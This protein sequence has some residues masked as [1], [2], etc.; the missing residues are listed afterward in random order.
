MI[1]K[2]SGLT[3]KNMRK[4]TLALL[5]FMLSACVHEELQVLV[6][7]SRQRSI[8]YQ[9]LAPADTD[10]H[11]PLILISHGSGGEINNHRWL[12]DALVNE[13][14]IAAAVNHPGNTTMDDSS[15]GVV[16]VWDRP[17]DLTLLLDAL[18]ADPIWKNRIDQT[19]IGAAGFSSGGYTALALAGARYNG[20]LLSEYC[21]A[22]DHGPDCDL[23]D[24][25]V[26]VDF[27]GSTA[28][29]R[30]D[31]LSAFFAMAPA[32]GS[33]ITVDSLQAIENPV[34][35]TASVDDELVYPRFSAE[36]YAEHIPG[37]TLNLLP[38]GGHFIFLEC[39][40]GTHVADWFIK[41]LDLCG[42]NFDVDRAAT[43]HQVAQQ[44]ITFF[45]T[46]LN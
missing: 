2:K 14:Y 40:V 12:M 45:D 4:L 13:G 29:Y 42:S 34:A 43:R 38:T 25:N 15:V 16:R 19:R 28:S 7:D 1:L 30:D 18:L 11:H 33:A 21:A 31:R 10:T 20:D 6:D 8:S 35:I 3:E 27:T 22:A 9:V 17:R 36:R 41:D 23:A 44:A 26:E 24:P 5:L 39:N 46:N 37:A 32:I